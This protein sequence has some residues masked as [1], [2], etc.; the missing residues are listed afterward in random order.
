MTHLSAARRRVTRI[1]QTRPDEIFWDGI[2]TS[3]CSEKDRH[4]PKADPQTRGQR[5]ALICGPGGGAE[6]GS[7]EG[8]EPTNC[9]TE[10]DGEEGGAAQPSGRRT[11]GLGKIKRVEG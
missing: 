2:T 6:L 3:Q 7:G 8:V 10:K 1:W 5:I 9:Q 11:G 4:K